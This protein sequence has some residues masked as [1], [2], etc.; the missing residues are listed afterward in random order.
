[1]PN[2]VNHKE[3][4]NGNDAD[5]ESIDSPDEEGL[6]LD[7]L[8]EAYAHLI[9]GG[10]DPYQRPAPSTRSASIAGASAYSAVRIPTSGPSM[11]RP[12]S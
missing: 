11:P 2:Q 5:L 3:V 8:S 1:M 10:I 6:S 12:C 7:Q 9:D 4:A